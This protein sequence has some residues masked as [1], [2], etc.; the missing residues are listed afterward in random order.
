MPSALACAEL[1][2]FGPIAGIYSAIA[3]TLAYFL[4]TSSRH[5]N[6]GPDGAVALL[7]GTAIL[8]LTGGD[9]AKA[10]IAGTWLAI[11]T[12][13]ILA[14]TYKANVSIS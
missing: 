9:P 4:F 14:Y 7:V 1:A 5:M 12:G 13:L 10:V 6:V 2:G 3:A 11:F 8:P